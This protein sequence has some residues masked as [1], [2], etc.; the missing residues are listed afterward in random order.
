MFSCDATL[1]VPP[2][3]LKGTTGTH[4]SVYFVDS[5]SHASAWGYCAVTERVSGY[6]LYIFIEGEQRYRGDGFAVQFVCFDLSLTPPPLCPASI[7]VPLSFFNRATRPRQALSC[8]KQEDGQRKESFVRERTS[9]AW[10]N[11]CVIIYHL[12]RKIENFPCDGRRGPSR[13]GK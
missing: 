6:W 1:M 4:R 10:K 2:S 7:L 8:S 9:V 13:S 3:E 11:I 12:E 5:W